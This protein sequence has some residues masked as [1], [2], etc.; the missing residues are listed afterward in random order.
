MIPAWT[1]PLATFVLGLL[2]GV[3]VGLLVR[4]PTPASQQAVSPAETAPAPPPPEPTPEPVAG[5]SL[6]TGVEDVVSELERRYKGR[7]VD[8][9]NDTG[10]KDRRRQP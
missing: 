3:G 7:K 8:P 6:A 10:S 1:L 2:V 9:A 4:R 5:P